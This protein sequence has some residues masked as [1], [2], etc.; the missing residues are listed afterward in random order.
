V[1]GRAGLGRQALARLCHALRHHA[2]LHLG[3]WRLLTEAL[4]RLRRQ[5]LTRQ[6]SAWGGQALRLRKSV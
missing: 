2:L 4:L 3:R 1:P 5:L 6:T